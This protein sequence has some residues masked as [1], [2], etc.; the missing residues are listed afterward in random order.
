M[1]NK[2]KIISLILLLFTSIFVF[3]ACNSSNSHVHNYD[4]WTVIKAATCTKPGEEARYCSCGDTQT[5][6]T[7]YAPHTYG[8]WTVSQ[9]ATCT[10]NGIQEKVCSCGEKQTQ[11]IAAG[12]SY[13]EWVVSKNATCAQS[14]EKYAICSVCNDKKTESITKL[15]THTYDEGSVTNEPTCTVNGIKLLTC[16]ICNATKEDSIPAL[17]HS[18]DSNGKCSIC[19][20]V[21]LNMTSTEIEKSK[22]VETVSHSISEYSDEIIINITLKDGNSYAVQVPTYVDVKIVDDNG[23]VLYS[24]TIIK[25]SSQSKVTIDYDKIISAVTNTGTL[26]YTIYNDYV[27]FNTISKELEKIPWT[28]SIELPDTPQTIYYSGYNS[29][30]CKVTGITYK[31]NGDDVTFYFTGEK[32]YD[33][34]G[35]SYSQSCKIGWKLYDEDGYVVGNGTCYTASISVGEKFKDEDETAYNVIEQGKTYR[36]VIMNVS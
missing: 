9:P 36:L 6:T 17:G 22:K 11:S 27:E 13:G 23:S 34:N 29:S 21:T 10:S 16:T 25:K 20:L 7:A 26:Y 12:H 28:V 18:V 19:G 14:G 5:R 15:S 8:E 31:V 24:E 35:D 32:T 1:T 3:S 4:E 33:K 30:S 2:I